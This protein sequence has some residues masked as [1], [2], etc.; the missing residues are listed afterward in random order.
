[1]S[2]TRCARI[3]EDLDTEPTSNPDNE[4]YFGST[5]FGHQSRHAQGAGE[6]HSSCEESNRIQSA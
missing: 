5:M 6:G 4:R 1:M 3:A 2:A